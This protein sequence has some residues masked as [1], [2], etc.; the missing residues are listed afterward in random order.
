MDSQRQNA[1]SAS[2]SPGKSV[3]EFTIVPVHLKLCDR[4]D[5]Q[6]LKTDGFEIITALH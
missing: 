6:K 4:N 3:K 5:L 1:V 2:E